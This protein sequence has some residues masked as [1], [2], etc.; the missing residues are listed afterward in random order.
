MGLYLAVMFRS[1]LCDTH[2]SA[3]AGK[4]VLVWVGG[5]GFVFFLVVFR[6]FLVWFGF[7]GFFSLDDTKLLKF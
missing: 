5:F 1:H 4:R 3:K 2:L 7:G 6:S